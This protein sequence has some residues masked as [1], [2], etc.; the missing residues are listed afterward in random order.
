MQH[1]AHFP[2]LCPR[3]HPPVRAGNPTWGTGKTFWF[4]V[5]QSPH[6]IH[7]TTV[8]ILLLGLDREW[9]EQP[10]AERK[11]YSFPGTRA[12]FSTGAWR[13]RWQGVGLTLTLLHPFSKAEGHFLWLSLYFWSNW[14][15]RKELLAPREE[16][17]GRLGRGLDWELDLVSGSWWETRHFP[18]VSE[19]W[20]WN[21]HLPAS[22]VLSLWSQSSWYLRF[23][24]MNP[25]LDLLLRSHL[26]HN[27][28]WYMLSN[29]S[30]LHYSHQEHSC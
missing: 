6:P 19:P 23:A 9:D 27:T 2:Q 28:Y 10:R 11:Q 21:E 15:C 24:Y 26:F 3:T 29:N 14:H 4:G 5:D 25:E 13:G 7:L 8:Q 16:Q 22:L 20:H 18:G 12:S 1:P 30:E 17:D